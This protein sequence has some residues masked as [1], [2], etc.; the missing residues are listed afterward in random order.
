M[1]IGFL[2]IDTKRETNNLGRRE[3][4]PNIACGK[5]YGYHKLNGDEIFYP[6]NNV[7]VDKLYIST[8]FTNTRPMI[9]RMMPLWEQRA[10]EIIIGGTGWD[11]YTKA[12]YTVTELPPEIA[13][14]SHVPWTYEMYNID[15]GIGFTTR[16]CHVGCAF[17]VVPKKEG[18]QEY[19]EMQVK[20]LINPRSNHLILMNN[21]SF[22]HRDFMND[23]EQIKFHN[24]S[25]H[26][27][28]A[29]DITLVTPEIAKAL[30]S[31]NYRGYNPNKKQLF[32]AFD[33]I[34]KKKIDQETGGTVTYDMMKIVPEKVK[35]LQ[36]YG[37][38]PYHLKFYM[39]IGFN[40]TEEEDLMRVDC[41]RE[42]NCDIYPMLFRDLNGKVGVDGNG[43]QQSFH[44]RAMRDWIHSGL[45]RKT[46]FKDFTRREEHR[47]QREKKESQ[48]TLF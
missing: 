17:C 39:L 28:Q 9:K 30:K 18:L 22:A 10:K 45:Y 8:I 44:V 4:Y 26:W 23:V 12:P 38:P 11:D 1:K 13:T 16:G 42:L 3:R 40:T 37:I 33:L 36:E 31:V 46:D 24:L 14:I 21:N 47:I 48:L 7:K 20:D 35:L 27:D 19:R 2:D 32:F 41:L 43:K 29:N 5:I 15:Y 34:T 6:Y 25:I